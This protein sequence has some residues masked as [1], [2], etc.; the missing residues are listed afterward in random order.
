MPPSSDNVEK[1]THPVFPTL[2]VVCLNEYS[3]I[4]GLQTWTGAAAMLGRQALYSVTALVIHT[5]IKTTQQG[6]PFIP[7]TMM[8]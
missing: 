6:R 5:T 3:C 1:T 7:L 4:G 2:A 8:Y